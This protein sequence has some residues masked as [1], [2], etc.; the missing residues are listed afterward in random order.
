MAYNP[1]ILNPPRPSPPP[2]SGG[3][4]TAQVLQTFMMFEQQRRSQEHQ[5]E[6]AEKQ[7]QMDVQ[8]AQALAPLFDPEMPIEG[9]ASQLRMLAEK[10]AITAEEGMAF[11][12][13][14]IEAGSSMADLQK[15][16]EQLEEVRKERA[17]QEEIS[18]GARLQELYRNIFGVEGREPTGARW[19]LF[20]KSARSQRLF[21]ED[22]NVPTSEDIGEDVAGYVGRFS[23]GLNLRMTALQDPREFAAQEAFG[24]LQDR[25]MFLERERDKGVPGLGQAIDQLKQKIKNELEF[26]SKRGKGELAPRNVFEINLERRQK[27]R[28]TLTAM[29]VVSALQ[30]SIIDNNDLIAKLNQLST[31]DER[32]IEQYT[33]YEGQLGTWA[34]RQIDKS[35]LLRGLNS[36]ESQKMLYQVAQLDAL[37]QEIFNTFRRV[38]TGA[39]APQAELER[40]M[41][42]LISSM[43][44][45]IEYEAKRKQIIDTLEKTNKLKKRYLMQG[46]GKERMASEMDKTW[47]AYRETGKESLLLPSG[48][49]I[50]SMARTLKNEYMA[51]DGKTPGM[52]E[53]MAGVTAFH[54]LHDN[55]FI[56]KEQLNGY[57]DALGSD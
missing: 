48:Q 26:S 27:E 22:D 36:E 29:P 10:G 23:E 47:K 2:Q 28:A 40:M 5:R 21:G 42:Q 1:P 45:P 50:A 8:K 6:M 19:D 39:A 56:T 15:K 16:Q 37:N 12:K 57:L 49:E 52:N 55:G 32:V 20:V 3:P 43:N 7:R 33:T 35:K 46:F 30:S 53:Y 18:K 51:G 17:R 4:S 24:K 11:Y 14:K 13:K 41:K 44:S 31:F 9:V 38:I 54:N 34:A 25:L